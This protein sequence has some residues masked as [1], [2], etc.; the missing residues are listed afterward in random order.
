MRCARVRACA[1]AQVTGPG[2]WASPDMLE[3]GVLHPQ[4]P[5]ASEPQYG[6]AKHVG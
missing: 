1:R 3:V 5:G 2:C 4:P 6:M